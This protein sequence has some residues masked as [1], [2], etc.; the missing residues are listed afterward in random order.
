MKSTYNLLDGSENSQGLSMSLS[1]YKDSS[2]YY[3]AGDVS[4]DNLEPNFVAIS[5]KN[6]AKV[7]ETSSKNNIINGKFID[8]ECIN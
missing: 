3:R 8:T 5:N 4:P 7:R 6:Q 2:V 1:I